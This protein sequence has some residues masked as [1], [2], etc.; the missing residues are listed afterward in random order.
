MNPKQ[1]EAID[2]A[3]TKY[4]KIDN[5]AYQEYLKKHKPAWEA[6]QKKRKEIE[7]SK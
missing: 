2:K 3:Y 6:Y 5:P 4:L 1:Q 7:A